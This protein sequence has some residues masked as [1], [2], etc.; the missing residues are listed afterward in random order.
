MPSR[1]ANPRL[2]SPRCPRPQRPRRH[3]PRPRRRGEARRD[4]R[5]ALCRRHRSGRAFRCA[6]RGSCAAPPYR[7]ASPRRAGSAA[8]TVGSYRPAG[9]HRPL[10]PRSRH[11]CR[12]A[13]VVERG[14]P[15]PRRA[16][17]QDID[18][19]V[20]E[21]AARQK[22]LAGAHAEPVRQP[23]H[24]PFMASPPIAPDMSPIAD[25]LDAC[26]AR[27]TLFSTRPARRPPELAN[28]PRSLA[29][30]DAC[31]A[32]RRPG[33][34]AGRRTGARDQGPVEP[35]RAD[36]P[37]DRRA[38]D[39]PPGAG[40]RGTAGGHRSHGGPAFRAGAAKGRR[41]PG[42]RGP[43]PGRP[44][45][46]GERRW[47]RGRAAAG[48]R[49]G[50]R[51][52]RRPN[53]AR[54]GHRRRA[55]GDLVPHRHTRNPRHHQ[56]PHREACGRDHGDPRHAG[57]YRHPRC[58]RRPR[59]PDFRPRPARRRDGQAA[60]DRYRGRS[61]PRSRRGS[62]RSPTG[63]PPR[64]R[65]VPAAS[66]PQLE[67][68]CA[69]SPTS[70]RTPTPGRTI[71]VPW[72]RSSGTTCP[73]PP[74][75]TPPTAGF[76]QLGTIE[77]G[78]SICSPRWRKSAQAPS[79]PPSERHAR[80]PL[81]PLGQPTPRWMPC[82]ARSP[83]CALRTR[84]PIR[85]PPVRSMRSSRPSN[86]WRA[87]RRDRAGGRPPVVSAPE[88]TPAAARTPALA[89]TERPAA[90]TA[91][92]AAPTRVPAAATC[93]SSRVRVGPGAPARAGTAAA[94]GSKT[95]F[96]APPPGR[97]GRGGGACTPR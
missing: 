31:P 92:Q 74:R 66:N 93:R 88:P 37:G 28:P 16:F 79:T 81:H 86:G 91:R 8:R 39:R 50:I 56:R 67:E 44:D 6:S 14:A 36:A 82:V 29:R 55:Q 10:D 60:D 13:G 97:Q 26:R 4:F 64:A 11:G 19:T 3:R 18:S 48:A 25:K 45:R 21:I 30:S 23:P 57:R 84:Q 89:A 15:P 49:T 33:P 62:A 41:V 94:T 95:A 2:R 53:D 70:S 17:R 76:A 7:H 43:G 32:D 78:L 47:P 35:H 5:A 85:R 1:A 24:A 59:R 54:R 9:R 75:S 90:P 46:E 68:P 34:A 87:H 22:A 83:R 72:P 58:G 38:G 63:W 71:R 65:H 96:I 69:V 61:P 20:A 51:A 80:R 52:D 12:A 73:S 40:R 77:R 42:V 27:S